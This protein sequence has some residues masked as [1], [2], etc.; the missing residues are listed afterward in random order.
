MKRVILFDSVKLIFLVNFA[1]DEIIAT[2]L[3]DGHLIGTNNKREA[4]NV[5]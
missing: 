1:N 5:T 2:S 4:V 3:F